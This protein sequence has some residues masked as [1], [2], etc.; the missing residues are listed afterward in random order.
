MAYRYVY[1][2]QVPRYTAEQIAAAQTAPQP[3]DNNLHT[4]YYHAREDPAPAPAPATR[5]PTTRC[6][7]HHFDQA[8]YGYHPVAQHTY[9]GYQTYYQPPVAP[10]PAA[11]TGGHAFNYYPSYGG[12]QQG[13]YYPYQSYY[14]QPY[15]YGH[16]YDRSAHGYHHNWYGR[17]STE[18][19]RDEEVMAYRNGAKGKEHEI[20]PHDAKP[21]DQFYCK[22]VDGEYILR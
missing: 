19:K 22:E 6:Y 2:N 11:T 1:P 21:S 18:V 16:T 10:A 15:G 7:T 12:A 5:T 17:T 8:Y 4:Y 20:K 3:F 13:I 14:S 9:T